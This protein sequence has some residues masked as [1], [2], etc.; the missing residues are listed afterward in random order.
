LSLATIGQAYSTAIKRP[1][2]ALFL[3]IDKYFM[4]SLVKQLKN[5]SWENYQ[6]KISELFMASS[7]LLILLWVWGP[8]FMF[9]PAMYVG[10]SLFQVLSNG[11]KYGLETLM[12]NL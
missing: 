11:A 8:K 12:T 7:I 3:A 5:L 9:F 4:G 6:M 10:A 1:N 2:E